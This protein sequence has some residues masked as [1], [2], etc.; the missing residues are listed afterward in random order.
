MFFFQSHGNL[1]QGRT[2]DPAP[3]SPSGLLCT[4]VTN[5]WPGV[6]GMQLSYQPT[7]RNGTWTMD[8]WMA[9]Y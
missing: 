3:V 5:A 6:D 1:P 4:R 7:E 2:A 8:G 9:G